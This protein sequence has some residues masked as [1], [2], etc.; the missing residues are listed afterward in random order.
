MEI[1]LERRF[2]MDTERY[3]TIIILKEG[4][5]DSLIKGE[6]EKYTD[7]LQG[8]SPYSRIKVNELGYK[9]LAYPIKKYETGYYVIFKYAV[10]TRRHIAELETLLRDDD[11]VLKFMTIKLIEDEDEYEEEFKE[12]INTVQVSEQKNKIDAYD[13]LL[14]LANYK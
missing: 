13:V 3:E 10:S 7:Y 4:L 6:I 1:L 5:S 8:I 11:Y 2:K 9:K 14:G 12:A